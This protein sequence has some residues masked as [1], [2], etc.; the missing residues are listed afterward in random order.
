M[1]QVLGGGDR[2]LGGDLHVVHVRAALLDRA[3]RG[4]LAGHQAGLRE[5]VHHRPEFGDPD[6]R[7]LGEGRRQRPVVELRE[8]AL[9]EQG[10]GRGDHGGRL[11]G[12]VHQRR[13]LLGERA[14]RGPG[15][16][17]LLGLPLQLLQLLAGPEGQ[18]A[19]VARDVPVVRVQPELVERVRRRHLRVEPDGAALALAELGAVRLGHQ[20]RRQRVH[21]G[22]R[23]QP[24][25]QVQA[26]R[27]VA[28]LVAAA[29]LER[30]TVPPV[31]LEEVHGLEELVAELRVA[32]ALGGLQAPGDR[33][34]RQHLVDAEVL[35]DVAEELDRGEALRPVEVVDHDRGVL[36]LEGQ[37]RLDLAAQPPD[38][39]GDR[40]RRVQRALRGRAWVADLP[41]RAAH[42]RQRP[43]AGLLEPAHGEHLH[44]VPHVQGGRGRVEAAIE[45]DG[46]V[47]ERLAQGVLVGG[48]GEEPAPLQVVD[49]VRH[50]SRSP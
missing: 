44:Q 23:L 20:R 17:A 38:P 6:V 22:V 18:D 39:A 32:D 45:R 43:V 10:L 41:G 16:R 14:L 27:E 47:R 49:D 29:L 13:Q 24:V 15:L 2:V 48:L 30:A 40:L 31:Q 42:Q 19:Q 8:V 34:F 3:A 5:Q 4:G 7:H 33:L 11:V 28:P 37:E 25:D 36:A 50:G 12:A 9:A 21:G 46:T 35:A 26:G 1:Q